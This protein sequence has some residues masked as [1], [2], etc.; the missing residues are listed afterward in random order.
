MP[1]TRSY[2]DWRGPEARKKAGENTARRREGAG[3]L[4]T[5]RFG[6]RVG[7]EGSGVDEGEEVWFDLRKT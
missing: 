6:G 2:E 5:D 7:A 1:P 4:G 3:V